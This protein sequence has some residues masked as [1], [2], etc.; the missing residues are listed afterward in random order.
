M[1]EPRKPRP[2]KTTAPAP[3][4]VEPEAVEPEP[5]APV[6]EAPVEP[7]EAPEPEPVPAPAPEP[8]EPP[9]PPVEASR[10]P[11]S[12]L[13]LQFKHTIQ[14]GDHGPVVDR[15]QQALKDAGFYDGPCDGRYGTIL[16]RCVRQFQQANGLRVTG[17]VNV[18]TWEAILSGGK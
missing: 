9:A 6:E 5:E 16:G 11:K 18:T 3:A 15:L 10:P 14:Q 4:A 13:A 2:R 17:A 8:V 12:A 7:V 1:A